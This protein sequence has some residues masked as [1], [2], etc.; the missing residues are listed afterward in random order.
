MDRLI[1][2]FSAAFLARAP[3]ARSSSTRSALVVGMPR[4]GTS[5]VEQI[6]STH[7]QVHGAGEMDDFPTM[8][9]GISSF[10]P[11]DAVYPECMS[12]VSQ[13]LMDQLV[14]ARSQSLDRASAAPVVIDKMPMNFLHL[15]LVAMVSPGA[16]V[17]HCVRD[18]VDTCLSCFFQHFGG[19]HYAFSTQLE[20]LASFYRQYDR[21][22]KH[23]QE[24]LPLEIM[25]VR[26][27]DLVADA[28]N[29]SR[30]ML[31]FLGMD[32]APQVLR[33]HENRR[34]VKTASYA[35]VRRPLYSTSVGRSERYAHRLGPLMT[36]QGRRD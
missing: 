27:E 16:R 2:T 5:L 25:T 7:P 15:G 10:V 24:V 33:F 18:P 6:L 3:K 36:L 23:W 13:S 30:R 29:V 8:V 26:Y 12:D 19:P 22:M 31:D 9:Q 20:S 17:I 4:S 34:T 11:G 28:E 35:Q 14:D 1:A 21:L 32:W